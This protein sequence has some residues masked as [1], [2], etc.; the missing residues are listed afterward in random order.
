MIWDSAL[1]SIL[2]TPSIDDRALLLAQCEVLARSMNGRSARRLAWILDE[3]ALDPKDRRFDNDDWKW[4]RI[5]LERAASRAGLVE[6]WRGEL[7]RLSRQGVTIVACFDDDYPANL[8]LVHDRPPL[9]FVQGDLTKADRRS[10][11]I[12]GTRDA[13]TEGLALAE[14]LASDLAT[15]GVT[16]VSGLARGIDTAA[17]SAA[18]NAGGRTIAVYG[19]TIDQVTPRENRALARAIQK[20]GACVSQFLPGTPTGR[21]SFLA[22][23][24]TTSG[25]SLGTLVVEASETSGARRQAEAAIAHGKRVFLTEALVNAQPWAAAMSE[26]G[27]VTETTDANIILEVLGTEFAEVI[28]TDFA[29]ASAPF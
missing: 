13:S 10:I 8:N 3:F 5:G 16:I 2:E 28:G 14:H 4:F 11:S 22:R 23:N 25:L 9:L 20:R 26:H 15:R 24:I 7:D 6:R 17:H 29:L 19:T 12:V 18:L 27:L 1:A 21:W